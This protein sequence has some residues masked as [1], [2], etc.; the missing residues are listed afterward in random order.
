MRIPKKAKNVIILVLRISFSGV[1]VVRPWIDFPN[2]TSSA[3]ARQEK[4]TGAE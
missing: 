1:L 3:S 2:E 4:Q